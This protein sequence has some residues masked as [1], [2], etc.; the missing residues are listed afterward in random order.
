MLYIYV[1]IWNSSSI[2]SIAIESQDNST[3]RVVSALVDIDC[4]IPGTGLTGW[5]RCF[6]HADK[7][8]VRTCYNYTIYTLALDRGI[9]TFSGN[10][11][12]PSESSTY[13]P[14][15]LEQLYT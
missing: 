13:K 7:L 12:I 10:E 9:L 11:R 1:Y 14:Q 3:P 5:D 8:G 2:T 15:P 4:I 6:F